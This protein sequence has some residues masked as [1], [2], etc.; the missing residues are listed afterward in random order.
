VL[1]QELDA[2]ATIE[3][4][5]WMLL[6]TLEVRTL[7]QA[8]EKLQWYAQRWQIEVY[9]RTLKSGCRI[10]ERQ[11]APAQRL[12]NCLAIDLVVAWRLVHLTRLGRE[13]PE[14]PCTIYF[15]DYQW[16]ALHGFIHRTPTPPATPPTLREAIRMVAG[17]GGFLGRKS[18]GEPG[19]KSMW[20]GLQ[21]LDDIAAAWQ[22]FSPLARPP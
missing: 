12:E 16:Q 20:L 17:L 4:L 6:T 10:E 8:V 9:H 7:E 2:P 13:T 22:I 3:P 15:D 18:D 19:P 11:L 21:R 14:A 5:T 1:A